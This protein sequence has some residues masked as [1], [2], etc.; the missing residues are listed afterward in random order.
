M[1]NRTGWWNA[2][3]AAD[4]DGDG[5]MDLVAGNYGKNGFFRASEKEPIRVYHHDY[6][7]NGLQDLLL[8]QYRASKPHGP[9]AEYPVS[10]RDALAEE[11]PQIKKYFNSYSRFAQAGMKEI[12]APF[13]RKGE[14]VL[15]ARYMETGW[16]E[17]RGK[18]GFRFHAFPA[19]A[20][21]SSVFSI[22]IADINQDGLPDIVLGGNDEG[23]AT[24]PGRSDAFFG[25][26]MAGMGKGEFKPLDIRES[27][28]FLPGDVKMMTAIRLG[29]QLALAAAQHQGALKLYRR[30]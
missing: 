13:N 29:N 12:L 20:Q 5:D 22:V 19:E 7:G 26:V 27:G 17:N 30:R 21:L 9:A 25:L 14:M 16:V 3:S 18:D 15:E 28:L 24:I 11:L 10:M 1:D 6:D 2:L 4:L 23:A 8:S